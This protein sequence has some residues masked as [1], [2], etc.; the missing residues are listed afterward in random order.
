MW[1]KIF[2]PT[3]KRDNSILINSCILNNNFD[4]PWI[5]NC[6][7]YMPDCI[8]QWFLYSR[9]LE[10]FKV[11]KFTPN[12]NSW[13]IKRWCKIDSIHQGKIKP[14]TL[15]LTVTYEFKSSMLVWLINI[16]MAGFGLI[17][18]SM[19]NYPLFMLRFLNIDLNLKY[20][21]LYF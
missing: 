15:L 5:I 4:Q 7:G 14:I 12:F 19:P 9:F 13:F 11:V 10:Y 16:A 20:Y 3:N 6:N 21:I 2:S 17:A 1:G 8:T 18:L